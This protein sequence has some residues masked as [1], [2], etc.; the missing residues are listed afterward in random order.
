MMSESTTIVSSYSSSSSSNDQHQQKVFELHKAQCLGKRD[1]SSAGAIDPHAVEI[2]TLINARNEYYTLSSCS[3]RCFLYQG[4]GNKRDVIDNNNNNNTS[5]SNI[6]PSN[7][8]PA[9]QRYRICHELVD[10]AIRYF[11]LSTLDDEVVDRD[12]FYDRTGTIIQEEEDNKSNHNHEHN[13]IIHPKPIWLRFEPFILHVMCRSL[14]AALRLMNIAR[15]AFKNVGLTTWKIHHPHYIVAIWGDE[16]LDMPLS[17]PTYPKMNLYQHD[18]LWLQE[19]INERHGKNW[20]KIARFVEQMKSFP[21]R[22]EDNNNHDEEMEEMDTFIV[23]VSR[24]E[25]TKN[26]PRFDLIGDVAIIHA[27]TATS[28]ETTKTTAIISHVDTSTNMNSTSTSMDPEIE[29]DY[30]QI[31]MAILKRHKA[32]R[33]VALRS[34]TLQGSERAPGINGMSII[35]GQVRSPLITTHTENG[36]KCIV[37]LNHTFFTPRMIHDRLRICKKVSPGEKVLILFC[38]VGMEALQVC[39]LDW[40]FV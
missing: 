13:T 18:L 33:I 24:L 4:Y 10:D 39:W 7:H 17:T 16:G 35:A 37:D 34:S 36:V 31:G 8:Q 6:Q 1:K 22:I 12:W 23:P 25:D 40:I 5:S 32:I 21:S 26:L 15:P 20:D 30:K 29:Y 27:A 9:F 19:L 2:C 3:G 28:A 11:D 38:G 14:S